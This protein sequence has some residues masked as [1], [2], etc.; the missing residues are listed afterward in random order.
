MQH[1]RKE[2]D[3]V[4]VGQLRLEVISA[5]VFVLNL[6]ILLSQKFKWIVFAVGIQEM[7]NQ[8]Q[9][10]AERFEGREVS[11]KEDELMRVKLDLCKQASV[12]FIKIPAW[13]AYFPLSPCKKEGGADN[14]GG[15]C[16]PK[17]NLNT[18]RPPYGTFNTSRRN[19]D[20]SALTSFYNICF[21]RETQQSMLFIVCYYINLRTLTKN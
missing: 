15:Y 12:D 21:D 3:A 2:M 4:C 10:Q 19:Q 17:R 5:Q 11:G 1:M 7:L 9:H 6:Y 14:L 20:E 18:H 8:A 13:Q 16:M